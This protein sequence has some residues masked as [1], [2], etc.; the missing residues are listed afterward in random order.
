MPPDASP[1]SLDRVDLLILGAGWTYQFLLPTL[2]SH[3]PTLTHAA[4]TR[5]GSTNPPT[6]PFTFDPHSTD[7][8]P[9]RSLPPALCIL[10]TFPI[11][12]PGATATLLRL[13]VE[14]HP[15]QPQ[16]EVIQL[17]STGVWGTGQG[18]IDRHNSIDPSSARGAEETRLLALGGVVL[19]LAGLWGGA[20]LP[21]NWLP[22]VAGDLEKLR[23]KG[24]LHLVHGEDVAR[25]V[26]AVVECLIRR[27]VGRG[28][29]WLL[30]DMRVYDWWD[31]AAAWGK[32][33]WVGALLKES[34]EEVRVLP[35]GPELLGRVLDAR[36]FW[37]FVGLWPRWSLTYGRREDGS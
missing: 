29:R 2:E 18:F 13:Y 3:T 21:R 15:H 25:G 9:Y 31:L 12:V 37:E 20:R 35:R 14:T 1:S 19:N 24:S 6:L 36:E 33:E 10:I 11:I 30:T 34:G 32:E 16:P 17:G 28:Q 22:R 5:S 8:T 23:A 4:T 27:G 7:P 26:L